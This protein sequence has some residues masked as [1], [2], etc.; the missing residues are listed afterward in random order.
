MKTGK[1]PERVLKRSVFKQLPIRDDEMIGGAGVGEDCAVFAP[2]NGSRTAV[3]VNTVT[4]NAAQIGVYAVHAAVNNIAAGGAEPT[5]VLIAAAFPEDTEEPQLR[6]I[7]KQIG[8]TAR[9]LGVTVAGGHTEISSSVSEPV[10]SVTGVGRYSAEQAH[11]AENAEGMAM[12]DK[13][14]VMTKWAGIAGTALIAREK[15]TELL[16]RYPAYFID[17]AQAMEQ[18]LSVVPEAATAGKSGVLLMHDA[19]RGGIFAAL[20]ELAE[21]AGVGLSVSL[22]AIPIR[23]ESVEI[24]NFLDVNP[25]E[26]AAGGSLLVVAENG[27]D[28]VRRFAEEGIPAA[29][30]GRT[31]STNDRVIINEEERRFLEP[32][33][34]DDVYRRFTAAEGR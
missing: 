18:W 20:W 27:Y 6:V 5:A 22:K 11:M 2:E 28:L 21:R 7:M 31:D 33:K 26:L 34:G 8:E 12:Y 13:D 15:R 17:E 24:C 9:T 1:I 16:T 32:P 4:G 30:I 14:I 29:V 10:L 25:Y 19:S 23:Q 3:C